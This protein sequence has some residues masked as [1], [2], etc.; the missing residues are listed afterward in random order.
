MCTQGM[1]KKRLGTTVLV[2][3]FIIMLASCAEMT[4][5]ASFRRESFVPKYLQ[6]FL[7]FKY[8]QV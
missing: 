2:L 4:C 7:S 6:Y 8:I 5:R 3:S 1:V